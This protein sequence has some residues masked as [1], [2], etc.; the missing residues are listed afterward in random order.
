[1]TGNPRT[2][3]DRGCPVEGLRRGGPRPGRLK[4][5]ARLGTISRSSLGDGAWLRSCF[6]LSR[7]RRTPLLRGVR[8]RD[9]EG[10]GRDCPASP[11]VV[12]VG[13]QPITSG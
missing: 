10:Q 3:G 9:A 12:D 4:V 13:E 11:V 5:A 6:G 1:M 8:E 2:T 7:P